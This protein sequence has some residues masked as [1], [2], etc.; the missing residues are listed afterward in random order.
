MAAVLGE[1]DV[2][3]LAVLPCHG[4]LIRDLLPVVL[5]SK[6]R[7]PGF[8]RTA[9]AARA[10]PGPV[11]PLD[12]AVLIERKDQQPHRQPVPVPCA[13]GMLIGAFHEIPAQ[14]FQLQLVGADLPAPPDDQGNVS[15]T[16]EML[17]H[18]AAP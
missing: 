16:G 3:R 14:V 13:A 4:A 8:E 15:G 11:E 12:P 9:I 18:R 10:D 7:P 2:L 17:A 5:G 6:H 1:A